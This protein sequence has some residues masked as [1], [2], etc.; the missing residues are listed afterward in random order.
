M[1]CWVSD[2]RM[3]RHPVIDP[4]LPT[5]SLRQPGSS[6][7]LNAETSARYSGLG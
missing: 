7:C 4:D 2:F 5:V 1:D 6:D 3:A